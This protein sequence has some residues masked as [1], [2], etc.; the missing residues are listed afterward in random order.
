MLCHAYA[1]LRGGMPTSQPPSLPVVQAL[2]FVYQSVVPVVVSS[3][4]GDIRKARQAVVIGLAIP[5]VLF[6]GLEASLLGTIILAGTT[7]ADPIVALKGAPPTKEQ[8]DA[9]VALRLHCSSAC[10]T[11]T[12]CHE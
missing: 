8:T 5:L 11:C 3:L 4:E 12:I 2:A 1:A 7:S 9:L 10:T 6:I